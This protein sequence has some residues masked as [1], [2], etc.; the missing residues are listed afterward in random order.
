MNKIM[1]S[2]LGCY[3]YVLCKFLCISILFLNGC[4]TAW[5]PSGSYYR[6]ATTKVAVESVPHG[7]VYI[8]NNYV[9]DTPIVHPV[10]YEEQIQKKSRK[11]SYWITQPGWSA[12]ISIC[13]LGIYIP[14][15]LIPVD[16]ETS[17]QPTDSFRNNEFNLHIVSEGYRTWQKNIFC[18]GDDKLSIDTTLERKGVD[19]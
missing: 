11:V 8:N 14:F 1:R 13:S 2:R 17:L 18:S 12:L 15:S 7:K 6:T 5:K 3:R 10:Q 16:V 4:A 9:G 19:E